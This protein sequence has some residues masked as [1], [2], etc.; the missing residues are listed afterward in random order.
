MGGYTALKLNKFNLKTLVI[1]F[2]IIVLSNSF[3]SNLNRYSVLVRLKE[4]LI[5]CSSLMFA[6]VKSIIV[7]NQH[8][9]FLSSQSLITSSGIAPMKS[10]TILP[11]LNILTEGILITAYSVAF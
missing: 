3:F 2:W 9:K 4:H 8:H 10:A 6:H 11:S 7:S 1:A 5:N